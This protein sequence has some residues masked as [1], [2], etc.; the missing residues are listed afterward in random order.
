MSNRIECGTDDIII[1]T[2]DL[3]GIRTMMVRW[4][5]R[6]RTQA[7]ILFDAAAH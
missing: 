2:S 4:L 6:P 1:D 5:A 3:T 7:E